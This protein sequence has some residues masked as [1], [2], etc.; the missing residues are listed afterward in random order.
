MS[1]FNTIPNLNWLPIAVPQNVKNVIKALESSRELIDNVDVFQYEVA[2]P[3]A[4]YT[5]SAIKVKNYGEVNVDI[6]LDI[7]CEN[8][9]RTHIQFT[10][11]YEDSP[12]KDPVEFTVSSNLENY[13]D[14]LY[15][16]KKF[17]NKLLKQVKLEVTEFLEN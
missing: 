8:P 6:A 11:I 17:I 4:V 12:Y 1:E 14:S 13:C 9:G 5:T 3:R 7:D 16:A 2:E 10:D 15:D